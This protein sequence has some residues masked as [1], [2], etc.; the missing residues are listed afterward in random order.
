MLRIAF[1]IFLLT[2]FPSPVSAKERVNI[3]YTGGLRGELEPCGCSPKTQSGGLARLSGY[4]KANM[5]ELKPLIILDA[6]DSLAAD[7]AQGRLKSEALLK[8][9]TL[10]GYDAAAFHG[11]RTPAPLIPLLDGYSAPIVS[12]L[13][14]R[15]KSVSV[16][17]GGVEFN[18]SI[19]P[20]A[21]KKGMV[22]VLLTGSTLKEIGPVTGWDVIISSSGEILDKPQ[23]RHGAIIV[24]GYPR[25]Q[26]LGILGLDLG[27]KGKVSGYTH[28]WQALGSDILEDGEVR[29]VLKEYEAKV[30]TL[31]RDED[32]KRVDQSPYLG[33]AKC[34]EC[35]APYNE[36]W[37]RTKHA[38][39]LDTLR[40]AGKSRN[41][42]CVACHTTGYGEEGGF[43]SD[44]ATPGL[45]GVQC[46]VCHGPGREHARDFR[47]MQ[48]VVEP[49][50]LKCHTEENSPSFDYKVYF[51]RINH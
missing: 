26:E 39:A 12:D 20:K 42:E 16:K 11:S 40:R 9:F 18:I 10:I 34:M 2:L 1:L 14:G 28:R 4:I 22:N 48:K 27:G 45:S 19:D 32:L 17:R 31:T 21:N 8:S 23:E 51:E 13:P 37:Q 15:Q 44:T 29:G 25:G 47:P 38:L 46:E 49:V 5:D 33:A 6:G 36:S 41:P 43:Y 50:C 24:A 7:T 35:H 30:A 3:L